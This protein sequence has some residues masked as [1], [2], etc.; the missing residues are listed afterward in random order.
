MGDLKNKKILMASNKIAIA[1]EQ[2]VEEILE[3]AEEVVKQ[4]IPARYVKST[5]AK[6]EKFLDNE[7]IESLFDKT[8]TRDALRKTASEEV[9]SKEIDEAVE[10]LV[11]AI[12]DEIEDVLN[13]ADQV[14]DET[15]E[16]LGGDTFEV[17]SKLKGILEKKMAAKGIYFR[18]ARNQKQSIVAKM[19]DSKKSNC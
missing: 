17:E 1:V 2:E 14:A 13:D 9:S 15:V 5:L 19:K 10:V 18:L 3:H 4:F 7:G 8:V 11:K 12:V 16:G 6:I